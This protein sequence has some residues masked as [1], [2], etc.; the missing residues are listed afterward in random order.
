[1]VSSDE[2]I[3]FEPETPGIFMPERFDGEIENP[4]TILKCGFLKKQSLA[5]GKVVLPLLIHFLKNET[6]A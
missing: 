1:M 6:D 4:D 3:E 5:L 2:E